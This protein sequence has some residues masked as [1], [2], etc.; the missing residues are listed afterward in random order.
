MTYIPGGAGAIATASDVALSNPQ[1][2]H[3]LVYNSSISKWINNAITVA[4]GSV[5]EVK[6]H[7][8]VQTKLNSTPT[9][10]D[11]G[12]ANVDNTSDAN[13]PVSSATQTALN[14]KANTSHIHA[15][16]DTTGL[17]TALDSK[18]STA[19]ATT[20]TNGLMSAPD[21]TKLNGV[22]TGATAN[23]TDSALRDR[24]THTGTQTA[25]TISDFASTVTETAVARVFTK[26]TLTGNY[27]VVAAD[28]TDKVLH[29]TAASAITITLPSDSMA[30]IFQEINIPW[31][32]YGAG[33][34]TFVAGSGATIVSRGNALKSAG[35]YAEGLVTKVAANTW[36]IG[37]DVVV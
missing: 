29:S 9:K 32:Q 27:I 18:A 30:A 11:L 25:S 23:A 17:Q 7:T 14:A 4:D 3:T 5:A 6:L 36:L 13:K 16:A 12:L 34:I 37:G 15:I 10:A 19:T 24:S 26:Q 1:D 31:R 33:Q 2:N 35:Q 21:K 20:S 22:A 28:A 8:D